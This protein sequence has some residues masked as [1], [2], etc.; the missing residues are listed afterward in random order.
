[1]SGIEHTFVYIV[2]SLPIYLYASNPLVHKSKS[3]SDLC[4]SLKISIYLTSVESGIFGKAVKI[5]TL[6]HSFPPVLGTKFVLLVSIFDKLN[7]NV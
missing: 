4:V 7:E 1:M 6:P 5:K 3:D 2:Y